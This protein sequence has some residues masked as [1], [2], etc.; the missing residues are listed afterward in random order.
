MDR[1]VYTRPNKP[2]TL[3]VKNRTGAPERVLLDMPKMVEVDKFTEC[4]V[5]PF[6]TGLMMVDYLCG[7]SDGIFLE[8]SAGTGNLIQALIEGG[9]YSNNIVGVERHINLKN[10]LDNRFKNYSSVEL[11]QGCFLEYAKESQKRFSNI[12]MNPPFTYAFK[13]VLAARSLLEKD[14]CLVALVPLTFNY[15]GSEELFTL[16]NNT[17]Q[18]AKVFTKVIRI[19]G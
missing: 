19:I 9:Y 4:H 10:V 12:I 18:S 6:E 15:E 8:P 2:R 13:H 7:R 1:S 5:T 3:K 11:V 14:G 16:S 17:F